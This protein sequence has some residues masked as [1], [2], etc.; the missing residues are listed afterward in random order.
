MCKLVDSAQGTYF[1]N[2]DVKSARKNR[3]N[4]TFVKIEY[5]SIL[6]FF[7]QYLTINHNP[8]VY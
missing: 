1:D 3:H 7:V 2:L 4:F 6:R 8:T 5:F